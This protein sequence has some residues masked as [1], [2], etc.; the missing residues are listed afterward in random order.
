[1]T[2]LLALAV[3]RGAGQSGAA[4]RLR[5]LALARSAAARATPLRSRSLDLLASVGGAAATD[6]KPLPV[7]AAR[8]APARA[9]RRVGGAR[10]AEGW[11]CSIHGEGEA[12]VVLLVDVSGLMRAAHV[13]PTRL[14]AAQ[15]ARWLRSPTASPRAS[16]SGLVSFSSGGSSRDPDHRARSVA[17]GSTARAEAGTAIRRQA[18][19]GSPRSSR[20]RSQARA[21]RRTARCPARSCCSPTVRELARDAL[22]PLDGAAR[23]TTRVS[24]LHRSRSERGNST[25]SFSGGPFEA[26]GSGGG[27]G[28]GGG[29]NGDHGASG[30]PRPATLA[31]IARETDG[32][33]VRG[34]IRH[35]GRVDL[36]QLGW[37]IAQ[38]QVDARSPRGSSAYQRCCSWRRSR[39]FD[40]SSALGS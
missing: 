21:R 37:G 11:R 36:W 5:S 15:K 23:A 9:R 34:E 8:V 10:A 17:R 30:T 14:G 4:R 13:K 38:R 7:A 20:R 29:G 3:A 25:L 22:T 40:A 28:G 16:G 26:T 1:M 18:Q 32:K 27:F 6:A 19:D 12:T 2:P 33:D 31:A 24:Y 35:Q 39:R